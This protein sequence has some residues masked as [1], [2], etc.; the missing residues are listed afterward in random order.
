MARLKSY[1]HDPGRGQRT[2]DQAAST[3]SEVVDGA[4]GCC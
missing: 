3:G 2:F 4:H 1:P